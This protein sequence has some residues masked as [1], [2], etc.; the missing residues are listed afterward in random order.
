MSIELISEDTERKP[1]LMSLELSHTQFEE[2]SSIIYNMCG[3]NLHLGKEA[4]VKAR[5]AKRLRVLRLGSF[6]EYMD[7]LER[8]SSG[9]ELSIMIDSLTTNKTSFFRESQHFD[10]LISTYFRL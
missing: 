1:E 7:Y 5:L 9:Q 3:I 6:K 8:D 2:I 10:Y 4:L